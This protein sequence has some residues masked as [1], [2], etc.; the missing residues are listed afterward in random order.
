MRDGARASSPR[1]TTAEAFDDF[2]RGRGCTVAPSRERPSTAVPSTLRRRPRPGGSEPWLTPRSSRS[3][4]AA[5]PAAAPGSGQAVRR[6]RAASPPP[7]REA[8]PRRGR[9]PR[10]KPAPPS[11]DRGRGSAEPAPPTRRADRAAAPADAAPA[12]DDAERGRRAAA[13]R[14]GDW[15]AALQHAAARGLRRPV[16]A[17]ARPAASPSCAAGSPATTR[18]TSSASTRRSPSRFLL[19]ALRPIAEKWFRVEVRGHRE[20]PGRGRRAGR[21]PTTPARSRSTR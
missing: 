5:A 12:D 14:A 11:A 21:R 6:P 17:A 13:S 16:G 8:A 19:A 15:L 4:R 18:S 7:A 9:G 20:H 10:R 1:Y 2:V 3:A